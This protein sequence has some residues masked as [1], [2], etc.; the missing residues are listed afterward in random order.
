VQEE[1]IVPTI[2]LHVDM[3]TTFPWSKANSMMMNSLLTT[4]LSSSPYLAI[5]P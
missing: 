2:P 5:G 1:Y 4:L 3:E